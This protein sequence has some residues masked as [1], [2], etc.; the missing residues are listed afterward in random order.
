M[1]KDDSLPERSYYRLLKHL[2]QRETAPNQGYVVE[3]AIDPWTKRKPDA[4]AWASWCAGAVCT[5]YL[6]AESEQIKI[7]G[8]LSVR[9][10]FLRLK[11][12]GQ[13]TLRSHMTQ[14]NPQR[15]DLVFFGN[16]EAD[17][18]HVGLVDAYSAARS[19][20]YTLEGNHNNAVAKTSR[21]EWYA[22][23]KVLY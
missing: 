19:L 11:K 4:T 22:L 21:T 18:H 12:L 3:W 15:G 17:L 23:A 6:E 2:G 7:V 1:Q 14:I 16:A 10:L 13:V 20:L 8:S 5:S 9:T